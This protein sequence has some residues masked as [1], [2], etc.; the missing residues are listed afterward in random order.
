ML[1][2]FDIIAAQRFA[3]QNEIESW[4]HLYLKSGDWANQ[5]KN[6]EALNGRL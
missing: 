4:V 2:T 6:E 1:A 5:P 3:A